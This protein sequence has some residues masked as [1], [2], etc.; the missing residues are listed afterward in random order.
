MRL[1]VSLFTRILLWF[2]VNLAVL[3]GVLWAIF[4]L[5]FQLP[6]DSPLFAGSRL[7]V[8][9]GWIGDDVRGATAR[10]RAR[11]LRRYSD[12]YG[13]EFALFND[14]GDRL[15]G[16]PLRLPEEVARFVRG[17]LPGAPPEAP[18]P[19]VPPDEAGPAGGPPGP[20]VATPG[21]TGPPRGALPGGPP[22]APPPGGL[23]GRPVFTVRTGNPPMYW[24]GVRLPLF[25]A[26]DRRPR[27]ATLLVRSDSISGHGLFFDVRP[28]LFVVAV[29]L[30]LS[31]LL[32]M[33]FVR[34]LTGTVRQLT[35]AAE[36]IAEERFDV[37]VNTRRTDELGRLGA[38]INQLAGRLA[39]FVRGQRR[40]LG[41]ISHELNT[42]LARLQFALGILE[43]RAD[44][45]NAGFVADAQ[46]EARVMSQLVAE[47]LAFAKA[48][49]RT[50][51]TPLERVTLRP[52][53]DGVCSREAPAGVIVTD[54]DAS[55]TVLAH[56]ELLVRAVANLVRNAVRYAGAAGPIT[57]SARR[58]RESVCLRVADHGPGVPAEALTRVFE[59]FF[60]VEADRARTTGGS[61]LGLAIV[62]TCVEACGGTVSAQNLR[63]TGFE[64]RV[65]LRA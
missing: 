12:T 46:E 54:I 63:P 47:L 21:W 28:W 52:L 4:N 34:G 44:P 48:G 5:Q 10:E 51:A 23:L 26:G 13:V 7:D 42:P 24:A 22:P 60:R 25:E 59:P 38:A 27:P 64:V 1:P 53:V 19:D 30:A 39:D 56:P 29:V 43:E 62:K 41:D 40:L 2:F 18:P 58:E 3:A 57:L 65:V 6:P 35:I 20:E 17:P 16:S 32:W 45:A 36:Q 31:I 37:P 61:G 11:I 14:T 55:L 8:V 15:A 50:Q 33:P 49:I 9:A